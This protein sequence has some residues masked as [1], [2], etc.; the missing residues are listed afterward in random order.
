MDSERSVCRNAWTCHASDRIV[1]A[2]IHCFLSEIEL[3]RG[4]LLLSD[5]LF[6]FVL[7]TLV[8]ALYLGDGN[9][10]KDLLAVDFRC[11]AYLR[12]Q[13]HYR[14]D[15]VFTFSIVCIMY[16]CAAPT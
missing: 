4:V 3:A 2:S 15:I 14:Y 1:T 6:V 12:K 9:C 16:Y 10:A 11:T 5:A 13:P 8:S 7:K